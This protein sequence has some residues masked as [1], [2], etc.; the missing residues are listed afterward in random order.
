MALPVPYLGIAGTRNAQ[1]STSN[2]N[3]REGGNAV[4]RAGAPAGL[5]EGDNADQGDGKGQIGHAGQITRS[6]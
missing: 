6:C 4:D 2:A 1:G 3:P 5:V